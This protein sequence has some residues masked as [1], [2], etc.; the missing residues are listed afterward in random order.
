MIFKFNPASSSL[1]SSTRWLQADLAEVIQSCVSPQSIKGIHAQAIVSGHLSDLFINN[2]LIKAYSQSSLLQHAHQLFNLMPHRNIISWSSMIS[3]YTHHGRPE[4]A[5]SLFSHFRRSSAVSPDPP[6]EFVLASILRACC[7]SKSAIGCAVQIQ[8]LAI[9]M[10]FTSDVFVGTA[11]ISF[12][13]RIGSME[14]AISIF[15]DLPVRTSATWTVIMAGFSQAGNHELSLQ[16]FRQMRSSGVDADRFVVSSFISA[17]AATEF[18]EGG[19]QAHGF[20]YRSGIEMDVSVNN[21][22]VDLYCKCSKVGTAKKVFERITATNLVSW[23]TMIA[24]Y[25]QNSFDS[26]S[27]LMFKKMIALGWIPDSFAC[28]SVLSSIGSLSTLEHGKQVHAHTIRA[29]LCFDRHVNNA[30]IDMYAKCDSAAHAKSLFYAMDVQDVV[31][32]NAMIE[33]YASRDEILDAF[34]LFSRMR[35][36][37]LHP[38]L[39]TFVSLIGVSSSFCMVD[40]T[41]Q[42]HCLM[43]KSGL[44]LEPYCGSALVDSYSKCAFHVDARKVFDEMRDRD[45]VV[46]NAMLFGCAKSGRGEEAFGLFRQLR[47]F[48]TRPNEFTLVAVLSMAGLF[49]S[50]LHGSQLHAHVAKEGLEFEP[51]VLNALVDMYAK[52]GSIGDASRLFD[53]APERDAACWNSMI[54]RCAAHGHAEEALRVFESMLRA[55]MAPNYVT[56]VGVLTAC[57]HAGLVGEGLSHFRAMKRDLGIEPGPEHYA[58]VVNLLGHAGRLGDAKEFI[59][60]MPI[61]PGAA[62]WRSLLSSCRLHGD[63]ELGRVAAKMAML[64]DSSSSGSHV[65]MSNIFASKCMWEDVERVRERMEQ[66]GAV[67]EPGYSWIEVKKEIHVFIAKGWEHQES[68]QIY[69]MLNCLALM[70]KFFGFVESNQGLVES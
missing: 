19:R 59:E 62:I 14:G 47:G 23:T 1:S 49:A 42:L 70:L 26:E 58:S 50:L 2:L 4:G 48:G 7:Q 51:H 9:K 16:I 34:S 18:L 54:S 29:H 65:L 39:V 28:S 27:L 25:M 53:G 52:C 57:C 10:G 69:S 8:G 36:S 38:T 11:L 17:C 21:V 37:S 44:T 22:L 45:L 43:I 32:Y 15:H 6:N 67:K 30:L 31:S 63:V 46:W 20:V 66:V 64:L 12:Y 40:S 5:L 33:G 35:S 56:Y 13:S 3:M 55:K 41:K 24:G 68:G 61:E 60:R